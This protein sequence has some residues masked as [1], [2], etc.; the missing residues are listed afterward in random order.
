MHHSITSI[1]LREL[2]LD[3]SALAYDCIVN[4]GL[5]NFA[6]NEIINQKKGKVGYI[7]FLHWICDAVESRR[8]TL[9]CPYLCLHK[10]PSDQPSIVSSVD[11]WIE[12][13]FLMIKKQ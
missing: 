8:L 12:Y 2:A 5:V 13:Y 4:H 1:L 11:K 9:G 3:T 10:P 6:V 7:G